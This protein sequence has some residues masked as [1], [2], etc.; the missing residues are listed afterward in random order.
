MTAAPATDVPQPTKEA[1]PKPTRTPRPTAGPTA[2]PTPAPK[3]T[4]PYKVTF[5]QQDLQ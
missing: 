2:T 1:T 3:L 4:N 5:Q